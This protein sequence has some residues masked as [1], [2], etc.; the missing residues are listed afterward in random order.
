MTTVSDIELFANAERV[1]G[2]VVL[3]TGRLLLLTLLHY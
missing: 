1:K 3:I 2:K